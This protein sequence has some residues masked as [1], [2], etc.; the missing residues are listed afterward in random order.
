MSKEELAGIKGL[1][2]GDDVTLR[3]VAG[4]DSQDWNGPEEFTIVVAGAR[5]SDR[6]GWYIVSLAPIGP[7]AETLFYLDDGWEIRDS[8]GRRVVA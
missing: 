4:T 5:R 2:R 1:W 3:P 8:D 7:D 6:H